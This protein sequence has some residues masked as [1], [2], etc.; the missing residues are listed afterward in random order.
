MFSNPIGQMFVKSENNGEEKK[1]KRN[2]KTK[3]VSSEVSDESNSLSNSK[4]DLTANPVV[5]EAS[6]SAFSGLVGIVNEINNEPVPQDQPIS[7]SV[8]EVEPVSG[9]VPENDESIWESLVAQQAAPQAIDSVWEAILDGT[10]EAVEPQEAECEPE[11]VTEE[12]KVD[13]EKEQ[14]T[15]QF[16]ITEQSY[17]LVKE[18]YDEQKEDPTDGLLNNDLLRYLLTNALNERQELSGVSQEDVERALNT[19]DSNN[20]NKINLDEFVQLLALFFSSKNNLKQR[21]NGCLNN[22]ASSHEISGQLKSKEVTKVSH[23]FNEFFGKPS[24]ETKENTKNFLSKI[25][26][27]ILSKKNKKA[28]E[29]DEEVID[30]DTF[31]AECTEELQDLCFVKF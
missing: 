1:K 27:K 16:R 23:F 21:I 12:P 8:A 22:Q 9:H 29:N 18:F 15:S 28:E 25:F 3:K 20:D 19:I 31:S 2:K 5:E 11:N 26:H 24:E 10:Q 4:P 13:Y 17:E 7:D 6:T 30:Y 14:F